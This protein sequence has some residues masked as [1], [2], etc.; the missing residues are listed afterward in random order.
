MMVNAWS[1]YNDHMWSNY[2]A[3]HVDLGIRIP[4]DA[5]V[6][7]AQL[8]TRSALNPAGSC[9]LLYVGPTV[10]AAPW[11]SSNSQAGG[12]LADWAMNHATATHVPQFNLARLWAGALLG[13]LP[14]RDGHWNCM[15]ASNAVAGRAPCRCAANFARICL[16]TN[17]HCQ[18]SSN[19]GPNK[20]VGNHVCSV[21]TA[22]AW[23]TC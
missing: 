13:L 7:H 16:P 6:W 17:S 19:C 21:L 9:N 1:L 12:M 4:K 8:E 15:T 3:W 22:V 11:D 23:P 18:W 5:T 2:A 14:N 20:W 10:G